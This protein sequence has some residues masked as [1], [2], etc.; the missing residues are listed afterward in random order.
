MGTAV[1]L[2]VRPVYN[3]NLL[4]MP[5]LLAIAGSPIGDAQRTLIPEM[6]YAQPGSKQS[7]MSSDRREEFAAVREPPKP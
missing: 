6:G 3:Q 1:R 2:Q 5:R 7:A 4:R